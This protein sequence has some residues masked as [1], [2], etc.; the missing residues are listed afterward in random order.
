MDGKESTSLPSKATGSK[1]P[2]ES[3][4]LTSK[5]LVGSSSKK[6]RLEQSQ[7]NQ[8]VMNHQALAHQP[9]FN[10]L[11][12]DSDDDVEVVEVQMPIANPGAT[13]NK[14][15]PV[16]R[17]KAAAYHSSDDSSDDEVEVIGVSHSSINNVN[18]EDRKV[19]ARPSGSNG[20]DL[21]DLWDSAAMLGDDLGDDVIDLTDS[22]E[23]CQPMTQEDKDAAYA[24]TL[25]VGSMQGK[26]K[27]DAEA[28]DEKAARALAARFKQEEQ[29]AAKAQIAHQAAMLETSTGKAF[30]FVEG[31]LAVHERLAVDL[32]DKASPDFIKPIAKDDIVALTEKLLLKQEEFRTAGKSYGIDLGYHYT[33]ETYLQSIQTGGL[34]TKQERDSLSITAAHNGSALG[35]GIYTANG[36]FDTWNQ[37]YGNIGLIVARLHGSV[38]AHHASSRNHSP[39]ADTVVSGAFAALRTSAQCVALMQYDGK[40]LKQRADCPSVTVLTP[41]VKSL[42]E[43]VDKLLNGKGASIPPEIV[44]AKSRVAARPVVA[45]HIPPHQL[46]ALQALRLQAAQLAKPGVPHHALPHQVVAHQMVPPPP[47]PPRAKRDKAPPLTGMIHYK[48]PAKTTS[49]HVLNLPV[50]AYATM[51]RSH[52]TCPICLCT[53]QG[54]QMA[55]L[56]GCGHE[57]HCNCLRQCLEQAS[58]RCPTCR[59]PILGTP[60][61]KMPSGIMKVSHLKT[62]ACAGYPAPRYITLTVL[63]MVLCVHTNFSPFVPNLTVYKL[64]THS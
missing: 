39:N 46:Q 53:S 42:Q 35:D 17:Y 33:Q 14:N 51:I 27:K 45:H 44:T 18:E 34:L 31:V 21:V 7:D 36:P 23:K 6:R 50:Q 60:F 49:Q 37:R 8:A 41:Y 61:G 12:D 52:S 59:E 47:P 58:S 62:K 3:K 10:N 5:A 64:P 32:K 24:R 43:L 1:S 57:L 4:G 54:Q 28:R 16:S 20:S 56:N 25:S 26:A 48:M 63:D 38:G 55:R 11:D 15:D 22:A 29:E 30:T 40:Q 9:D 19:T 13:A 2:G